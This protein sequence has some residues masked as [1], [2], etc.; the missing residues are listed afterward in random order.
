MSV[1]VVQ[2]QSEKVQEVKSICKPN[3]WLATIDFIKRLALE[4]NV[5]TAILGEQGNGKTTFTR[6]MQ[7]ELAPH[8]KTIVI[9][10]GPSFNRAFFLQRIKEIV[11]VEGD[12]SLANFITQSNANKSQVL[13]I[14]DD[15]QFLSAVF[16]EELLGELQRQGDTGCFHV[17]LASD[18]S[19]VPI[20]NKLAQNTYKEAI[21]S[22]ELGVL[23]ESETKAYLLQRLMPRKQLEKKVTDGRV[24]QFYQLTA[25]H[26]V[27]INRQ[28]VGFF[29]SKSVSSKR[30]KLFYPVIMASFILLFAATYTW[31]SHTLRTAPIELFNQITQAEVEESNRLDSQIESVLY[32]VVPAYEIGAIRQM[33]VA[34][35]IRI[36]DLIAM[37]DED[38]PLESSIALLD[39]VIVA[40]KI[41]HRAV[42]Q[43]MQEQP[44]SLEPAKAG[45]TAE[46]KNAAIHPVVEQSRYTIQLLASHNKQEL[47]RFVN[48]HHLSGKVQVRRSL[49]QGIDWYV[50]TLGEYAERQ[51]A[52][53]AVNKLPKDIARSMPW[54][55]AI[56]DLKEAG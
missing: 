44:E 46:K 41:I 30:A 31:Q 1:E 25:G 33:V 7:E 2:V 55:R 51:H 56:A 27:D 39:K 16:V 40:P 20:L 28:M 23:S 11:G 24:K 53:K 42:K 45:P 48:A 32:S 47:Q 54:V 10:A 13:L 35:P 17:C 14:I 26:L 3:S 38:A 43:T 29:G 15:A 34:T 19:L 4:N 21:H 8:M 18:F 6:L 9:T 52:L 36:A 5:M 50:L 12:A 37:N 49:R 22:I